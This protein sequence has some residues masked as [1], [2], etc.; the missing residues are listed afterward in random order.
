MWVAVVAVIVRD[1]KVLAMR[2]S[3]GRPAAG[4][5]ETLS[6]RVHPGEDPRE[7]VGREIVEECGLRTR[8]LERPVDVYAGTRAGEPM[9]VVVFRADYEAGEVVLS[10]EHDAFAW[11][12]PDEVATNVRFA[13]LVEAVR[14]ALECA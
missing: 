7:A 11:W 4:A 9:T 3:P 12:T 6:G 1:G 10:D 14:R 13:R 2:R 8:L 5:W